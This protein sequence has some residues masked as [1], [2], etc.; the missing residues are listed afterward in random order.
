MVS[1]QVLDTINFNIAPYL[2]Y[3]IDIEINC[4]YFI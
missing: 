2:R 4:K 3:L 1:P